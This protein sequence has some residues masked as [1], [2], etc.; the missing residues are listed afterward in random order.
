MKLLTTMT[1]VA[2]LMA[3]PAS[4]GNLYVEG[5]L[6]GGKILDDN[7]INFDEGYGVSLDVGGYATESV[8]VELEYDYF[9][10]EL[11]NSTVEVKNQSIGMN[12]LYEFG[13]MSGVTP[14]AGAGV[15]GTLVDIEGE[16]DV[17]YSGKL[18]GGVSY[19]INDTS[20]VYAEVKYVH[21]LRGDL[22]FDDNYTALE[23]GYT[24]KF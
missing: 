14:Y 24:Y 11:E 1:C 10:T 21:E 15:A 17:V 5:G 13:A 19:D 7:G 9:E 18:I 20:A 2:A 23:V 6:M 16:D 12:V 4:A 3:V 22:P 8:K